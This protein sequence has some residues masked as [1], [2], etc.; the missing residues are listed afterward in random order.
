[1]PTHTHTN[2]YKQPTAEFLDENRC[3]VLEGIY[4]VMERVGTHT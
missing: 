2:T 4:L 3:Y 1:M